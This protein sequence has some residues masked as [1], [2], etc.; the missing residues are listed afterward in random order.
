M[1]EWLTAKEIAAEHLPSLPGT[2]RN[3]KALAEREGWNTDPF[4]ARKR[5]GRGGG[6]EYHIRLLPTV[7]RV[8]YHKRHIVVGLPATPNEA[9]ASSP[10]ALTT[11]RAA[12]ERDAR[13]AIVAQF[14]RFRKGSNLRLEQALQIFCD[15]WKLGRIHAETWVTD[16]VPRI[17]KGSLKRWASKKRR[18]LELGVDRSL[19][20]KGTGVLDRA[21]GGDVRSF[22]LG[23]I[24]HQPHLQADEVRDQVRARFGDALKVISKGVEKQVP[25]PPLRTFQRAIAALKETEKVVL[26]KLTNPDLYRSTM[27]LSGT[28]TMRH[29]TTP[30]MHWQIDASPVDALCTDGRYSIYVCIDIATR[31]IV[32]FLSKTPRASAVALLIRKAIL[33]WGVP[34]EIKTDNGSDFTA[35]ATRRL[36]EH[37]L[38]ID[39]ILSDAFSPEQKGFVERVIG[40]FQRAAAGL[41][42]GFIGHSVADRKAIESRRSFAQRLGEDDA[43]TFSVQCTAAELQAYFDDWA[44]LKYQ[45]RAHAGLQGRTPFELAASANYTIRR[46]DERALDLLLAPIAGGDGTRVMTKLGIRVDNFHY[47]NGAILPGTRVFIRHDP[48]DAGRIHLF[49]VEDEGYLGEAI[50]AERAGIDPGTFVQAQREIQS[51]ILRDKTREIEKVRRELRKG[52]ALIERAR[53]VWLRDQPNVVAMPKPEKQHVTPSIAAAL[54]AADGQTRKPSEL[55]GRAAE[56]HEEVKADLTDA[57]LT[58]KS[59]Q[60]TVTTLDTPR[61]RFRRALD[62]EARITAGEQL[63]TSDALWLGGYQQSPEY[64]GQKLVHEDLGALHR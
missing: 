47:L 50:C 9:P 44:N 2:E 13:L 54:D 37:D 42:P 3:I 23:L 48:L 12:L 16:V 6:L 33:L 49:S 46:V 17:S 39:I 18:G 57:G 32:L 38:D 59:A 63:D 41:V 21:E 43:D 14:E 4:N 15:D 25:M 51:D 10:P 45:H 27:K 61:T 64:Q 58:G 31:R 60:T 26:T 52:P 5:A 40:T 22:M 56:V 30:N 11:G 36:L 1:K 29:V 55:T 62:L 24:A 35:R 34:D 53:E 19:S 20:R 7:A 28:G 8:A